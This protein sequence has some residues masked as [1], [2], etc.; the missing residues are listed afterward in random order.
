[1]QLIGEKISFLTNAAETTDWLSTW[2]KTNFHVYLTPYI[3]M[4]SKCIIHLNVR[5]KTTK[6]SEDK[7]YLR[8]Q[9]KQ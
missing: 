3:K 8:C 2:K 9:V 4:N 1:M 6:L 5:P 7:K